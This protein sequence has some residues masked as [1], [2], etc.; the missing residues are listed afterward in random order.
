MTAFVGGREAELGVAVSRAADI[1]SQARNPVI[2]GLATD[3]DGAREAL[4]LADRIC[5][6]VDHWASEGPLRMACLLRETGTLFTTPGEARNR[7]DVTVIVGAAPLARDFGL[8]EAALAD[9]LPRPGD[10]AREV[11]LISEQRQA[12]PGGVDKSR[13]STLAG[14]PLGD[15]LPALGAAVHGK[16]WNEDALDRKLVKAVSAAAQKLRAAQFSLFAFAPDEL[17]PGLMQT[18]TDM[19]KHLNHEK[20]ATTLPVGDRDNAWG[21]NQL[22]AWTC[23]LPLR[24]R[25]GGH[26]PEHDPIHY[27]GRRMVESGDADC[28]L[29]IASF[30]GE[31]TDIPRRTTVALVPKGATAQAEIV[32]EVA[33][34]G[35]DHDAALYDAKLG[36]VAQI[37]ALG[38]SDLPSV[39][40]VL[41]RILGHVSPERAAA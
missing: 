22:C 17:D 34:P 19:V 16:R 25:L 33:T 13:I 11:V 14:A 40:D 4:R 38:A 27:A 35:R 29:W 36:A 7:P 10:N 9:G 18:I 24:T 5:A 12:L 1:L 28:S 39:A 26:E 31:G 23:G 8:I 37:P 3:M 15:L 41:R 2:A 21:V 30:P 6:V 20:R 32:I